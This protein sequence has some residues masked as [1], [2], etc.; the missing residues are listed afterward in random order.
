MY[1][2][3]KTYIAGDWT[4]DKD[5]IDKLKERNLSDSLDLTFSDVHNFIQA[6]DSSLNCSIKSSLKERLDMSKIFVL[7]VGTQTNSL[8]AGSCSYCSSYSS[9][10][11]CIRGRTIDYR[12]Y[13]QYE[14]EKAVEAFHKGEIKKIIILYNSV[15]VDKNKCP[16]V[17][18]NIGEHIPMVMSQDIYG[19][20]M[21]NYYGVLFAF[22]YH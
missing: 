8:K 3:T 21:W 15:Y 18:R 19:N 5:A 7:V 20:K 14:C 6:R 1:Y 17:L 12:S 9:Y 4:G 11:W 2:R 10:G 16:L 22:K 13:I